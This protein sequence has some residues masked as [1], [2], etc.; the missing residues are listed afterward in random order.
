MCHLF[1][2]KQRLN[3]RKWQYDL[4]HW[5]S[6]IFVDALLASW[7]MCIASD[8]AIVDM[9]FFFNKSDTFLPESSSKMPYLG[10]VYEKI[11]IRKSFHT[12]FEQINSF[13]MHFIKYTNN[14]RFDSIVCF[15]CINN[16][17]IF[18]N[19]TIVSYFSIQKNLKLKNA[20]LR[21]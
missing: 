2:L 10:P 20:S 6:I 14:V 1:S 8:L 3:T 17:F 15:I 5:I 11:S 19:L 12:F 16:F 7:H 4:N 9:T 13:L 18:S 21:H